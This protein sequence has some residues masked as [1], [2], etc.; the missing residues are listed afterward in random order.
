M[1]VI[2]AGNGRTQ[3]LDTGGRAVFPRGGCDGDRRWAGEATLDII[4]GFRSTLA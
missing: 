1:L 3:R 2:Q 4:V